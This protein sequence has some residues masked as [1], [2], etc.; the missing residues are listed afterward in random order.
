MIPDTL[1]PVWNERKELPNFFEGDSLRLSIYDKDAGVKTDDLL[2]QITLPSS[3]FFPTGLDTELKL[4]DTAAVGKGFSPMLKVKISVLGA[5]PL[6]RELSAEEKAV[7]VAEMG[8]LKL[9]IE[10]RFAKFDP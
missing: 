1:D 9:A 3:Q 4:M 7:Q 8:L 10:M 2:G 6:E 5:P